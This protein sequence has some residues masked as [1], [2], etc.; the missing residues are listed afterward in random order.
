LP[1]GRKVI[2][3]D[4]VGFISDLPTSLIDAFRATLEEV[5]EAD[6]LLHVRDISHPETEAQKQDVLAVLGELGRPFDQ[7]IVEVWNKMD[8]LS[9]EEALQKVAEATRRTAAAEDTKAFPLCALSGD[10]CAALLQT[11]E[12]FC[13]RNS[14]TYAIQVS[15]TSGKAIA[16]FYDHGS[17][18]SRHDDDSVAHLEVVLDEKARAHAALLFEDALITPSNPLDTPLLP[19]L[20]PA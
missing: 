16:W 18:L 14:Q 7:P 8:R 19:Q 3:S 1:S 15:L 5:V 10:G 13:A 6:L 11:I 12:A 2:F 4:T 9:E 17:V 20:E